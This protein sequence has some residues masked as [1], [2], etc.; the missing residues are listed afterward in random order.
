MVAANEGGAVALAC[1]HYLAT[2]NIALVYMQNSGQGNAVNPLVSLA[3]PEVYS[4]PLLALIGW[5]GEPEKH[6]EL[7]HI[8]Q[9]RITL[10]LLDTL[11]VPYRVLPDN[12]EEVQ[13]CLEEIMNILEDRNGPVALIVRKGTFEPCQIQKQE[14][15]PYEMTREA[16]LKAVVDNLDDS[17]VIVS[18]TGKISREL[19]EYRERINGDHSKDFLTLGSMGHASQIA[20]GVAL[21]KPSRQVY[22]L[23]G[24]GAA[25]MHM[26]SLAI[27]GSQKAKNFKHIIFNNGAHDSVGGQPTAGFSVLFTAIAKACGYKIALRADSLTEIDPK[28]EIL[29]SAEGPALL[30]IRVRKGARKNLGRPKTSPQANKTSFMRFLA[31]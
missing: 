16:A 15:C 20:L 7:Q 26:G 28:M 6:D 3:Y 21:A 14:D 27:V 22:C 17:S 11:E 23:D 4:V 5:R 30:E 1:G 8:K 18:T 31:D 12:A 24:D 2:G 9:G 19:Y 25:I 10:D 13:P 29:K